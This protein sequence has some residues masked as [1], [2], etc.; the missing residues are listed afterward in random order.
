MREVVTHNNNKKLQVMYQ[1]CSHQ[2]DTR[3]LTRAG[4]ITTAQGS[5][6]QRIQWC[7]YTVVVLKRRR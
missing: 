2:S 3:F 7:V 4:G 6:R 5:A 1:R